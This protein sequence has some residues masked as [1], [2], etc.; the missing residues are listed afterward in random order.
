MYKCKGLDAT[1]KKSTAKA[2]LGQLTC[3]QKCN[4]LELAPFEDTPSEAKY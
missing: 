3:H 1:Y 2:K 4:E